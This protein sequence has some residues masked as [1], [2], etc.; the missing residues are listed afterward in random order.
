VHVTGSPSH[1]YGISAEAT[2]KDY[3]LLPP[4]SR[5]DPRPV[6]VSTRDAPSP[7]TRGPQAQR[8]ARGPP[9]SQRARNCGSIHH[10]GKRGGFIPHIPYASSPH[11]TF[12]HYKAYTL[13]RA[14][15]RFPLE[16][17]TSRHP[18]QQGRLHRPP[19]T[20]CTAS[21]GTTRDGLGCAITRDLTVSTHCYH[22]WPLHQVT[23]TLSGTGKRVKE[24]P[25]L[26]PTFG[27]FNAKVSTR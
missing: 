5:G 21:A 18:T 3:R 20:R 13:S 10:P 6:L 24:S 11:R 19:S 7:E 9:P 26:P 22:H 8:P 16:T 15:G 17:G 1:P 2:R 12:Q 27:S 4:C 23:D 14:R 25:C